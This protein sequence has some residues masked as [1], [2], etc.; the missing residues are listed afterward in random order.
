MNARTR[1]M[2]RGGRVPRTGIRPLKGKRKNIT[3]QKI[4][5]RVEDKLMF[6]CLYG[7]FKYKN[8]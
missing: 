3:T 5:N 6:L 4:T 8:E 1:K 2:M 7:E